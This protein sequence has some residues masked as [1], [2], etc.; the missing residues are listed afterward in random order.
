VHLLP[1]IIAKFE[2]EL[3]HPD[4]EFFNFFAVHHFMNSKF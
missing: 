1:W 3:L 4:V 2:V